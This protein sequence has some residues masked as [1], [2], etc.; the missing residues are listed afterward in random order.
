MPTR[1]LKLAAMVALSSV[2]GAD[3]SHEIRIARASDNPSVQA[4]AN[5]FT[6]VVRLESQFRGDAPARMAGAIV[7]FERGARTN[8]HTHPLGQTLIVT[9]GSG[10]VQRWGGSRQEI[11]VGD[12]VWIP[13]DTKHWHGASESTS[14][15]H[16]AITEALDGKTVEWMEKVSDQQYRAKQ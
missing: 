5:N 12:V 7:T 11:K 13:A 6:G 8:W 9:Q 1:T 4:P 2:A 14:M 15:S 16:V 10:F 3:A